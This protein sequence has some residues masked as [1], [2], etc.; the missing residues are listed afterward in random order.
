MKRTLIAVVAA[1]AIGISTGTWLV[2]GEGRERSDALA[3]IRVDAPSVQADAL[4]DERVTEAEYADALTSAQA[5]ITGQGVDATIAPGA[6]GESARVEFSAPTLEELRAKQAVV[7]DCRD[8]FSRHVEAAWLVQHAPDEAT[9]AAKH[10]AVVACM[11]DAGVDG[12]S[13]ET[14]TDGLIERLGLQTTPD[15]A[16]VAAFQACSVG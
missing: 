6:P 5:C 4:G 15:P 9:V 7:D 1:A 8:Q 12:L 11:M 14:T 10:R 2:A 16:A 13:A 3:E